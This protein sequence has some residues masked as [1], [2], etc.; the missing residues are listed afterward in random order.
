MK[1]TIGMKQKV[2]IEQSRPIYGH[3][4]CQM[5]PIYVTGEMER[6]NYA[7][8]MVAFWMAELRKFTAAAD[9]TN[10]S[11]ESKSGLTL[12]SAG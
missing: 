1:V 7:H 11:T 4:K 3:D 12:S 10:V 2:L 8:A 9:G 5:Y 6:E